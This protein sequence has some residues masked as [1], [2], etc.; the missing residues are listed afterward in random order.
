MEEGWIMDS[1]YH[2]DEEFRNKTEEGCESDGHDSESEW[3]NME[4]H[5]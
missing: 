2:V 5:I 1:S 3:K 4:V